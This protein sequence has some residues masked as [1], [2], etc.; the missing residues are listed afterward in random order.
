MKS[1]K[2]IDQ[3]TD[4]SSKKVRKFAENEKTHFSNL[5]PPAPI[6]AYVNFQFFPQAHTGTQKEKK[7]LLY[8]LAE[9]APVCE[10]H[11]VQHTGVLGN[12]Q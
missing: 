4:G 10:L 3:F 2:L 5:T 12:T 6:L 1:Q 7:W 8:S 9:D 11:T